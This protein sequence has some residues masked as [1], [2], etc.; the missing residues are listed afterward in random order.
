M[1]KVRKRNEDA[2]SGEKRK[3]SAGLAG[4]PLEREVAKLI[5]IRPGLFVNVNQ[6]VSV[7]VLPQAEDNVY[8]VLKLSNG[9]QQDL[10]RDEFT[11]IT[12]QEPRLQLRQTGNVK[13]K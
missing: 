11:T 10:T 3:A 2:R 4:V 9:E 1:E 12:G 13:A 6:I 5:Q 8:A 7:R